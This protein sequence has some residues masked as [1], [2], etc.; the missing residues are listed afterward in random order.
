MRLLII[1]VLLFMGA[2]STV[3]SVMVIETLD[4]TKYVKCVPMDS[5]GL[6]LIRLP[7][8]KEGEIKEIKA[9][10]LKQKL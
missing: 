5:T 9:K 3:T 2:C 7:N 8:S 1:A 6:Y 10:K 4:G